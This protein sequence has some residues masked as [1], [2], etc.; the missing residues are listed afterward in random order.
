MTT[1]SN[2]DGTPAFV[3]G[4]GAVHDDDEDSW[5]DS[6]DVKSLLQGAP[7]DSIGQRTH[8]NREESIVDARE[9]TVD[10]DDDSEKVELDFVDGQV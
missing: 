8:V 5:C 4:D 1:T 6:F 7:I 10:D 3:N 9:S 2:I